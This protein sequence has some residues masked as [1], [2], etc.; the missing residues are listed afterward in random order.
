M[1]EI[2]IYVVDINLV[3]ANDYFE[4]E[5]FISFAEKQNTVFT[6]DQF[7]DA[8]NSDEINTTNSVI[9]KYEI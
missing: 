6:L 5:Q 9:R 7:I 3:C 2:M 1:K 8:L 4:K